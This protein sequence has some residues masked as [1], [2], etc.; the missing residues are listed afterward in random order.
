MIPTQAAIRPQWVINVTF[1]ATS[2]GRGRFGVVE[3][4][5]ESY[6]ILALLPNAIRKIAL[7]PAACG[8]KNSVTSSS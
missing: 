8:E 2:W 5:D 1:M 4:R 3:E 7:L 6:F